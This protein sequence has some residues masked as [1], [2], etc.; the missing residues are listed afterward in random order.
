MINERVLSRAWEDT[1]KQQLGLKVTIKTY[2]DDKIFT[3]VADDGE[4]LE[5]HIG[6]LEKYA[7]SDLQMYQS[8]KFFHESGHL[9]LNSFSLIKQLMALHPE[10]SKDVIM[11]AV[12]VI[13]DT[14]INLHWHKEFTYFASE[15]DWMMEDE[16]SVAKGE[17]EKGM[18]SPTKENFWELVFAITVEYIVRKELLDNCRHIDFYKSMKAMVNDL[19]RSAEYMTSFGDR[20]EI[21]EKLYEVYK[22]L[23]DGNKKQIINQVYGQVGFSGNGNPDDSESGSKEEGNK[24]GDK[25][26]GDSEGKEGDVKEGKGKKEIKPVKGEFEKDDM[27]DDGAVL[28]KIFEVE[29]SFKDE[30]LTEFMANHS[31]VGVLNH[32]N[33]Y[34]LAERGLDLLPWIKKFLGG[35]RRGTQALLGVTGRQVY[36]KGY[37]RGMVSNNY[38]GAFVTKRFVD[39]EGSRWMFL[40]DTSGS[41][42]STNEDG[43]ISVITAEISLVKAMLKY[44]P[45]TIDARIFAFSG[46]T[47]YLGKANASNFMKV[48]KK[49]LFF[50]STSWD[51][52]TYKYV[53]RYAKNGYQVVILSDGEI[54][55]SGNIAMRF[56]SRFRSYRFQPI[57]FLFGTSLEGS[58]LVTKLKLVRGKDYAVFSGTGFETKDVEYVKKILERL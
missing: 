27:T 50:G 55:L 54:S 53:E 49:G 36:T 19:F 17:I 10:L 21:F 9:V 12:N 58:E 39:Y 25:K 26:E 38:N 34:E 8:S 56:A 45:S 11:I 42:Q 43:F 5:M 15:Y 52:D 4:S 23:P 33:S 44:L 29:D 48:I 37:V 30:K 16:M 46:K 51:D 40:I 2:D 6:F 14:I 7:T 13:D 18:K 3:R 57:I 47:V 22:T 35:G 1:L 24:E 28:V 41:T 32:L 31:S 20:A